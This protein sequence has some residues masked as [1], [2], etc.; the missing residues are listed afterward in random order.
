MFLSKN[1]DIV[2]QIHYHRNGRAEKDHTQIGIYF[3][4]KKVDRPYQPGTIAG[5]SGK[6]PLRHLF[7]IPPGSERFALNGDTWATKDFTLL[8]LMPHMHLLG[9]EVTVT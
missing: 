7:S 6:G 3:A 9:K 4:K 5:G 2:L 8:S 1:S